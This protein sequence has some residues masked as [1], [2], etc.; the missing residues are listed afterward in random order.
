MTGEERYIARILLKNKV[1]GYSGQKFEDLFVEIMTKSNIEFQAVK[2]Y[3]N[4][5]DKKN[6][7]FIRST[8]T[9]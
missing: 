8:G 9:Y 4:I 5:G 7:G 2:A 6:D 1:L 3:G